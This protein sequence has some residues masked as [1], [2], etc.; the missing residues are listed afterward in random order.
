MALVSS[1]LKGV[2]EKREK[3]KKRRQKGRLPSGSLPSRRKR[4]HSKE[5]HTESSDCDEAVSSTTKHSGKETSHHSRAAKEEQDAEEER[6]ALSQFRIVPFKA[7]ENA[8]YPPYDH[9]DHLLMKP[10]FRALMVAPPNSGKTTTLVN[11]LTNPA[12]GWKKYF[13]RIYIITPSLLTDPIWEEL[14]DETLALAKE[15][16]DMDDL[17]KIL[18]DNKRR[19]EEAGKKTLENTALVVID[20]SLPEMHKFRHKLDGLNEFYI[21]GRHSNI[22]VLAISQKYK[23]TPFPVRA[24]RSNLLLWRVSNEEEFKQVYSENQGRYSREEFRDIC[25][26]AWG[27]APY[28]FLHINY[29]QPD[30]LKQYLVNFEA[31]LKVD[32]KD[33]YDTQTTGTQRKRKR[34]LARS[35]IVAN[36][37]KK[38]KKNNSDSDSSSS[39]SSSSCGDTSS[40]DDDE[41]TPRKAK[42]SKGD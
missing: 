41:H 10:P 9:H 3:E 31:R 33:P 13:K 36:S 42:T 16:F 22:S 34:E 37:G 32:P 14:D 18:A 21:R 11:L 26:A 20:D 7:D 2:L 29:Q 30:E 27:S 19:V 24:M 6:A 23:T 40:S 28:A 1:L 25:N 17:N 4:E 5:E 12:F 38:K 8:G 39:S 15:K 35:A